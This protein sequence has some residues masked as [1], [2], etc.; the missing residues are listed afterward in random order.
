MPENNFTQICE[1]QNC[2]N[3]A[4]IEITC[5]LENLPANLPEAV[6]VSVPYYRT[7]SWNDFSLNVSFGNRS[8]VT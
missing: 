5:A 1:C 3:E 7:Y 6:P 8:S 2:G 4:E